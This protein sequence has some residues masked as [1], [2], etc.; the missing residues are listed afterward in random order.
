MPRQTRRSFLRD[1]A[2]GG[3]GLVVLAGSRFARTYAA[4]DKLN[5]ALIG[6]GGRGAALPGLLELGVN[7]FELAQCGFGAHLDQ[8]IELFVSDAL[9]GGDIFQL[10]LVASMLMQDFFLA[11]KSEQHV[12]VTA[13][14][15]NP[16]VE[17]LHQRFRSRCGG[18][19]HP[20]ARLNPC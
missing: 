7:I 17:H 1:A 3:A 19:D 20:V 15:Q 6:A 11:I 4:N 13:A 18:D 5:V 10:L 8:Y 16:L 14:R 2:L 9:E 12:R